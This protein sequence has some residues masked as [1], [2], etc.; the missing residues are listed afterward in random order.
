MTD[1]PGGGESVAEAAV[2]GAVQA[3][4]SGAMPVTI[5]DRG[6]RWRLAERG[7]K[8]GFQGEPALRT[9]RE[10]VPSN[11][12]GLMMAPV[13]CQ[14]LKESAARRLGQKGQPLSRGVTGF[15][16]PAQPP[17][18]GRFSWHQRQRELPQDSV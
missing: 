3:F 8:S 1:G 14:R 15:V 7:M 4:Q 17:K 12:L 5:S 11:C 16:E 2:G 6:W 9:R 13:M 10:C 18:N